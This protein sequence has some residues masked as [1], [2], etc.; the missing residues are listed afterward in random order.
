[1]QDEK[2]VCGLRRRI[3]AVNRRAQRLRN[4]NVIEIA[5]DAPPERLELKFFSS[6]RA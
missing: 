3:T 1:M 4:V 6:A 5:L 2:A